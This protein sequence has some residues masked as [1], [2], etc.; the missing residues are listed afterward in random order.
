MSQAGVFFNV[1]AAR[2]KLYMGMLRLGRAYGTGASSWTGVRGDTAGVGSPI[3]SALSAASGYFLENNRVA[4]RSSL[5][6]IPIYTA[7]W[8]WITSIDT[9]ARPGDIR[10]DGTYAFTITGQPDTSQELFQVAPAAP[11]PLGEVPSAGNTVRGY[12]SP[13]FVLGIGAT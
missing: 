5:P 12:R 11:L 2:Y 1:S 13:L 10:T 9:D 6:N 4:E 8:W 3:F 7:P